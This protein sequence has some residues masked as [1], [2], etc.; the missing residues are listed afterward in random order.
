[1]HS[2]GIIYLWFQ[3]PLSLQLPITSLFAISKPPEKVSNMYHIWVILSTYIE[4][5]ME[6][7]FDLIISPDS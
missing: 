3:V 5:R 1:M 6:L 4:N 2:V 7:T